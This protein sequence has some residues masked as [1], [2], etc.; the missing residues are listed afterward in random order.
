MGR[1]RSLARRFYKRLFNSGVPASASISVTGDTDFGTTP[2]GTTVGKLQTVSNEA[3]TADLVV[4]SISVPSGFTHDAVLPWTIEAGTAETFT[5]TATALT[6]DR[7]AGNVSIESNASPSPYA[8]AIE[9]KTRLAGTTLRYRHGGYGNAKPS[10]IAGDGDGQAVTGWTSGANTMTPTGGG[11]ASPTYRQSVAA[12]NNRGCVEYDGG[13]NLQINTALLHSESDW[14]W[15]M[16]VRTNHSTGGTIAS[17]GNSASNA[18]MIR[19]DTTGNDAIGNMR[20]GA[21]VNVQAI[22]TTDI[23]NNAPHIIVVTKIGTTLSIYVDN[24]VTPQATASTA[25]QGALVT[26]RYTH[27]G[28]G[29]AAITEPWDGQIYLDVAWAGN[30]LADCIPAKAHYGIA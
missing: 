9:A 15:V 23:N 8:Y 13:D 5:I 11:P 30:H 3:G 16:V 22:G 10:E 20:D 14:T 27:A 26:N 7:F 18:P 6:F 1:T 29:R 12:A 24:L 25:A 28:L 2:I 17:E 21:S 4:T 19:I